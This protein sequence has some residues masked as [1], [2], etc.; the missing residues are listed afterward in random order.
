MAMVG[1]L[2]VGC[3]RDQR[4]AVDRSPVSP[5][6]RPSPVEAE[7]SD[8]N[9]G[10]WA[11]TLRQLVVYADSANNSALAKQRRIVERN[12]AGLAERDMVVVEIV[13]DTVAVDGKLYA[14]EV[15]AL[16]KR[17]DI[18]PDT[19]FALR[20]VGKDTGIKLRR[21]EPVV[22]DRVFGLIDT[23]PMRRQEQRGS[24]R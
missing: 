22:M 16:K 23:M 5:T 8:L 6:T 10:I 9:P 2:G 1:A 14:A 18:P 24:P 7:M 17:Y 21:S 4:V 15:S 11:W 20:L 3:E 12:R 13:G 19:A